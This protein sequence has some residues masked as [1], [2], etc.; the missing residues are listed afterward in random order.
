MVINVILFVFGMFMD[1]TSIVI[2]LVPMF[3]PIILKL[4]IDPVHFGILVAINTSIG[5]I[6][7]PVGAGMFVICR[8]A[9]I[10]IGTFTKHV[11]P[12]LIPLL[13]VLLLVTFWP[14]MVMFLPNLL[15]K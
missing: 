8:V 6:T 2:L 9:N 10:S 5:T 3:M 11:I 12:L 7:P 15:S 14:Q 4:G 13:A 1:A